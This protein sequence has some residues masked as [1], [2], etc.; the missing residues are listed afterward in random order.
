[1]KFGYKHGIKEQIILKKGF[2]R[3]Y[4]LRKAEKSEIVWWLK[5][6]TFLRRRGKEE[7]RKEGAKMGKVNEGKM[8]IKKERKKMG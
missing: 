2:P 5:F 7:K 4:F 1:M 6:S 8:E 3:N